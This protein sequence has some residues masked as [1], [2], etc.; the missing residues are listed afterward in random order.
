MNKYLLKIAET[1]E[2]NKKHYGK[3]AIA[4]ALGISSIKASSGPLLGYENRYHG[5]STDRANKIMKE[6]L[7]PSY[8]GTGASSKLKEHPH[9]VEQSKNK[10][11]TTGSKTI[12]KMF[13][14]SGQTNEMPKG[15]INQLG[16]LVQRKGKVI[17][18]RQP[19]GISK[20]MKH[21]NDMSGLD[22][23]LTDN[24][25]AK[26]LSATTNHAIP[27]QHLKNSK[28]PVG[29]LRYLKPRRLKAY[30]GNVNHRSR[31][32]HGAVSLAVG[33]GLTALSKHYIDK[34][35]NKNVD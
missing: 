26:V 27:A 30:Y 23:I 20:R 15:I 6:G 8:G 31:I 3:A 18:V 28:S 33:T 12:A 35:K 16:I 4:G 7:K 32:A 17:K 34:S 9:L 25:R 19:W 22:D 10:I 11:H 14:Y 13:A 29:I 1:V 21:D 24:P 2:K 5:T